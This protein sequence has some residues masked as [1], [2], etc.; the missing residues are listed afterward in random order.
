MNT[1]TFYLEDDD[2]KEVNSNGETWTFTLQMTKIGTI[3]WNLRN[4]KVKTSAWVI[5]AI[6]VQKLLLVK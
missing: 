6:L 4:I 3:E 5:K 2:H 1:I